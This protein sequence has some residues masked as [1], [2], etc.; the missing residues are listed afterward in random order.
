MAALAKLR[1]LTN[2]VCPFAH[3]AWLALEASGAA[4]EKVDVT[5]SAGKK[6]CV[7]ARR[8]AAPEYLE[9][10]RSPPL[11]PARSALAPQALFHAALPALARRQ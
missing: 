4:Y 2:D 10:S 6:E 7:P 9:R 8:R 1:F 11:P 5:I 3:R